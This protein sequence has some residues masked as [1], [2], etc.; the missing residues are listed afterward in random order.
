M[1]NTTSQWPQTDLT[2]L[3]D[4]DFSAFLDFDSIDFPFLDTTNTGGTPLGSQDVNTDMPDA[5]AFLDSNMLD[6]DPS[7]R[8][9]QSQH[10]Y[11]QHQ[12][13]FD[14]SDGCSNPYAFNT[15]QSYELQQ[16]ST[17][18]ALPNLSYLPQGAVPPT[19]NSSVINPEAYRY[20][21][22]NDPQSSHRWAPYQLRK[23]DEVQRSKSS[24]HCM[25]LTPLQMG[26]NT[27]LVSPDVPPNDISY[28]YFH[29]FSLNQPYS[30]SPLT[31]PAI[32]PQSN[33]QRTPLVHSHTADSSL[34]ASPIDLN[35]SF[36]QE[37]P[38]VVNE[39]LKRTRRKIQ[40]SRANSRGRSVAIA[41]NGRRRN[42]LSVS[43]PTQD[44][45]STI[46]EGVAMSATADSRIHSRRQS[47][48]DHQDYSSSSKS[49][50]PQPSAEASMA[51][52]P[53]PA[54][55][56]RAPAGMLPKSQLPVQIQ[57]FPTSIQPPAT[58]ASM[59]RLLQLQGN[60]SPNQFSPLLSPSVQ[61][62]PTFT[63]NMRTTLEDLHL[64]D[65]AVPH[66]SDGQSTP[67]P[68]KV[69]PTCRRTLTPAA[70][71]HTSPAV[72]P[73]GS[74][75]IV[76]NTPKLDAKGGRNSRKRLSAATALMSPAIR[77]KMSPSIKPLLPEGGALQ[78]MFFATDGD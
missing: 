12:Q 35:F 47:L 66:T 42:S 67:R 69:L 70:S 71:A 51:P 63:A 48:S 65:A 41:S 32:H 30:L 7:A 58:P 68:V 25:G 21:Q 75:N 74:P 36:P 23:D 28:P 4:D 46:P 52:P 62:T 39:R 22:Q 73:M 64:P 34:T 2:T 56:Y 38:S 13:V 54:S 9:R 11:Y 53:R 15:P 72:G 60:G 27:P 44:S 24:S 14:P 8:L 77:P 10:Q 50:S 1:N 40:T 3:P 78:F 20:L 19:P 31:S 49:I 29:D 61:G 55:N 5:P 43:I 57:P 6:E 37:G 17:F 26:L 45:I 33:T 18:S 59:M 76:A 16:T